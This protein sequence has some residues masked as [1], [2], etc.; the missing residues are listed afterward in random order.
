MAIVN[1]PLGQGMGQ[2]FHFF[3][4]KGRV[5]KLHHLQGAMHLVNMRE[6]KPQF[7][8]IVA[9]S[10]KCLK[11]LCGLLKSL[12]YLTGYPFQR[13]IILTL[14]HIFLT[15]FSFCFGRND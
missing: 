6:A 13:D 11:R 1:F 5:K 3:G 9:I 8:R 10:D 2:V 14:A 7:G 15:F 12:L 4:Q